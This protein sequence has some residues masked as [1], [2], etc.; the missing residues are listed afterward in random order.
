M[1][2]SQLL[3]AKIRRGEIFPLFCSGKNIADYLQLADIVIKE[4]EKSAA[5][6]E[7][8]KMLNR[9]IFDLENYFDDYRLVRGLSTLLERR[10]QFESEGNLLHEGEESKA[11]PD[12]IRK[13]LWEESSKCGFALTYRRRDEII[14]T[15]ASKMKLTFSQIIQSVWSDLDENATLERFNSVRREELLGWYDLSLMQ[16]L[17]FTCTKLEF[18]VRGGLNWKRILRNVKRLGLMY[19]LREEIVVDES[20][21]TKNEQGNTNRQDSVSSGEEPA[22]HDKNLVCSVDGPSSLFKLTERYGTSISRL[23]PSI[24]SS[25]WWSLCASIV[26]RTMSG[27]KIYEFRISSADAN[28]YLLGEPL[29]YDAN[30]C[31]SGSHYF[32]STTE[33]TFATRF[34]QLA[35]GWKLE[36][37]PNPFVVSNGVAFIPDF[38][39]EKYGKKVYLEIVGFWTKEYLEK[40]FLKIIDILHDKNIDLFIAVS[41]ELSCSKF[42]NPSIFAPYSNKIIFYKRGSVPVKIIQEHLKSIDKE[43][44][45]ANLS[46]SNLKIKFDSVKD[47]ISVGELSNQYG[48]PSDVVAAIA[49]RD[50]DEDYL[51][52]DSWF[53]SKSKAKELDKLLVNTTKFVDACVL[54]SEN[55]IP[56]SCHA[57]LVSKLGYDIIWRSMDFNDAVLVRRN[58]AEVRIGVLQ[59]ER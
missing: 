37:E 28:H 32:D 3:R 30:I 20:A 16:T 6:K 10:C 53:V 14:H 29:P 55:S 44:I 56:E 34:E 22:N 43:Q 9:R 7:S 58:S 46:E 18:C 54:L 52:I 21:A 35:N 4:F 36:R 38:V 57:E 33:A 8:K 50:N 23:L 15:V 49:T 12:R 26:R 40:K 27:R 39:F 5:K 51:R 13:I 45:K 2:P 24:V 11:N 17:L 59:P 41:D 48:L 25:P 47:V 31:S 19:D 1:L 42:M